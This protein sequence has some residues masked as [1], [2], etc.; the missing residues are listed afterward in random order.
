MARRPSFSGKGAVAVARRNSDGST[1]IDMPEDICFE[2][3]RVKSGTL[4]GAMQVASCS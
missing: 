3:S 4:V 1:D 2:D